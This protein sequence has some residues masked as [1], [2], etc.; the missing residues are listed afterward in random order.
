MDLFDYTFV[1]QDNQ[2]L[3]Y[4]NSLHHV[5]HC[6]QVGNL[7]LP[8]GKVVA[9]DPLIDTDGVLFDIGIVP[10]TY[11]VFV[12]TAFQDVAHD[13]AFAALR[14]T[15]TEPVRWEPVHGKD[16]RGR[17]YGYGVD[18][19]TGSFMDSTTADL[20]NERLLEDEA[21]ASAM[22]ELRGERPWAAYV[23]PSTQDARIYLFCLNGDGGYPSFYG[24]DAQGAIACV[25]TDF[26]GI[27]R[28]SISRWPSTLPSIPTGFD[29]QFFTWLGKMNSL[30][31]FPGNWDQREALSSEDL[32]FLEQSQTTILPEDLRLH[33]LYSGFWL[34]KRE[35]LQ[36]WWPSL[37]AEARANLKTTM[38]M[39]PVLWDWNGVAV[40]DEKNQYVI[41]EQQDQGWASQDSAFMYPDLKAYLM[42]LVMRDLGTLKEKPSESS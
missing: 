39:L 28:Q 10:G 4:R 8:S 1:F 26:F 35:P 15:Q 34:R 9:R 40:C 27:T 23:L 11:P 18:S 37:E 22:Y 3:T 16:E 36:Q 20:L 38:P 30:M 25:V 41:Y 32:Q 33:Y 7:M 5:L 19:A 6:Q 42:T 17:P 29:A 24:Y 13:M 31:Q 21:C 2:V 14:F 12:T